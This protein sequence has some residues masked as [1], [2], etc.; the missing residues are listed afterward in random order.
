MAQTLD[1]LRLTLAFPEPGHD[2]PSITLHGRD[3]AIVGCI[4]TA[5]PAPRLP[6]NDGTIGTVE[7][8]DVLEHVHDE[9]TWLAEIGR[10]LVPDGDVLV[11]VPLENLLAWADALNLYRYAGDVAGIG[12]VPLESLPT[13]WHRHYA[14]TDL[15]DILELAGFRIVATSTQGLPLWEAGHL[16]GL[17]A[18]TL[19]PDPIG[20]QRRLFQFRSRRSDRRRLPVH[21]ALA[22]TMTVHAKR[23]G[24]GYRP[25]PD[26][27][28]DHRP[29]MEADEGLE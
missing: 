21:R 23:I 20:A 27:D 8:L 6:L 24:E 7:A 28:R 5:E 9:Q 17:L 19:S 22:A 12:G 3:G 1:L 14:P 16:A 18:S 15:P 11:R 29:E 10:V 4:P 2:Q 13:G 26:L 25:A